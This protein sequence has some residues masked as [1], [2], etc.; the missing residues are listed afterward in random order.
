MQRIGPAEAG[1]TLLIPSLSM[2]SVVVTTPDIVGERMAGPGIRAWHLARELSHHFDTTLIAKSEGSTIDGDGFRIID[3]EAPQARDAIN[4]ASVLVGQPARG[5]RKARRDQKIVF[6]L[7]DPT[8]LELREL[9]GSKP[10]LRQRLHLA[11]E[12]ARLS[13]AL[14]FADL[15][16]CAAKKQRRFYESL[17]SND[18]PWIEVPFGVD[19]DETRVCAKSQ[20]NLVIWGGGI[21][22]WLDPATAV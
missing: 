3:R 14:M 13:E 19:L 7:F 15:L 16:M 10:S 11:A 21:W 20:D 4:N 22:E 5:F 2:S 1:P 17:Q 12:W 9:Y 8:V 18:A 6:D